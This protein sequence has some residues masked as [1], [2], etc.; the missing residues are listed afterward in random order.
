MK[1]DWVTRS[2]EHRG[3]LLNFPITTFQ[4]AWAYQW[5]GVQKRIEGH[6]PDHLLLLEHHSVLTLGRSTKSHHWGGDR[7][8]WL[9]QGIEI[10]EI[11][12]GGSVT[13]HGPGQVVGYPILSLRTYC[14]GPKSYVGMLE[15]VLI[16]VLADWGIQGE[17]REK[18]PG[19]WVQ[20][21]AQT[22]QKIA[23]IGVKIKRGITMHGFALNAN[24]DLVPFEKIVPCGIEGCVVTSMEKELGFS[25]GMGLVRKK[26]AEHF[27]QVFGI[28]W[29]E[30]SDEI[31]DFWLSDRVD[32]TNQAE[33]TIP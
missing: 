28:Q 18:C 10:C 4:T 2:L 11:E 1:E 8:R 15:E 33:L 24:V 30:N 6:I 14:P 5:A 25:V 26:I 13:Y 9:Q 31:P 23:A 27:S 7:E 29:I 19:V 20:G 32:I 21:A 17:R 3:T 12:R 22:I 16:R